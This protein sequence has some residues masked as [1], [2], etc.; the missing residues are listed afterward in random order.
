MYD[1]G[2]SGKLIRIGRATMK[3]VEAQ[4]QFSSVQ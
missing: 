3:D 2:I 1:A 4:V